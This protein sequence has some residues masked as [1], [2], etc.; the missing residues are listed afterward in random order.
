MGAVERVVGVGGGD[1]ENIW[2][3]EE[4]GESEV[5]AGPRHHS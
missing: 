2:T 4:G 3:W 1:E 5:W